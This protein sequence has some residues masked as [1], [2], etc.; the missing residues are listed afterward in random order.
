MAGSRW[1]RLDVDYFDNPKVRAVS[2]AAQRLHLASILYCARHLTDG[3]ITDRSLTDVGQMALVDPRWRLRRASELVSVGLWER[4]GSG[5]HVHDFET[6]NPQAM[7]AVVERE[8]A[9]WRERQAA[10][11]AAMSRVESL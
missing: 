6:M 5:W 1:V 2:D 3:E 10:R 9:R 4:N 8:R 7:R 11:R